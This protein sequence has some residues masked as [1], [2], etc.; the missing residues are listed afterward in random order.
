M[1]FLRALLAAAAA[2]CALSAPAFAQSDASAAEEESIVVIGTPENPP[3]LETEI[4]RFV[5]GHA[6][7][8]RIDQLA[9]WDDPL[10]VRVIN[11]PEAFANFIANR[12]HEVAAEAGAPER[13][14]AGCIPTVSIMFTTEPQAL[15]DHIRAETPDLLGAYFI[16]QRDALATI[17]RPIQ[18]W[19]VTATRTPMET[20]IDR[21]MRDPL[22]GNPG[23]R[24]TRNLQSVFAHVLIVVD[25]NAV[26]DAPVGP[27]AD[28]IAMLSL[29]AVQEESWGCGGLVTIMEHFSECSNAP[30]ELTSA[31]RAFLR[32]LYAMNERAVGTLQRGQVRGDMGRTLGG[33]D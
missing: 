18:A 31:D 11:L 24:I 2:L 4:Q 28:Y 6:R 23:S 33:E 9:R 25:A 21:P 20:V 12:V 8:S 10:C 30:Q 1:S 16:N 32:G 22:P 29:T 7:L 19:Y 3:S 14:E 15:I 17:R 5:R 26:A 13:A 27:I